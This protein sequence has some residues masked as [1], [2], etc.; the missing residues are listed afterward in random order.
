[1]KVNIAAQTLSSSVAD[2]MEF[3]MQFTDSA[4]KNAEGTVE[5]IRVFG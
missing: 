3:L 2:A 4:F 5:F 1:M